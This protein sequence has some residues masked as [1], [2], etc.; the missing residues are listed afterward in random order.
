MPAGLF[1]EAFQAASKAVAKHQVQQ[2]GPDGASKDA[3]RREPEAKGSS[4]AGPSQTASAVASANWPLPAL[5]REGG[6]R[7]PS[8]GVKRSSTLAGTEAA[9]GIPGRSELRALS[10]GGRAAEGTGQVAGD[11]KEVPAKTERA[12][13]G[14]LAAGHGGSRLTGTGAQDARRSAPEPSKQ[15][16]DKTALGPNGANAAKE[17]V[18]PSPTGGEEASSDGLLAP[19]P[20]DVALMVAQAR[21]SQPGEHEPA[22]RSSGAYMAAQGRTTRTAQPAGREALRGGTSETGQGARQGG[23]SATGRG[24]SSESNAWYRHVD[25]APG[26]GQVGR[27]HPTEAAAG[28]EAELGRQKTTAPLTQMGAAQVPVGGYGRAAGRAALGLPARDASAVAPRATSGVQAKGGAKVA[29]V[30]AAVAQPGGYGGSGLTLS[31]VPRQLGQQLGEAVLQHL[32]HLAP[33]ERGQDG[34]W[35]LSVQLDPPALGKV[36]ALLSLGSSGLS[37]VLVPSTPAAWQALQQASHQI[38]AN[39]GGH[40]TVSLHAGS[41]GPE[42]RGGQHPAASVPGQ[43]Q[44]SHEGTGADFAQPR[45]RPFRGRDGYYILA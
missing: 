40:V 9:S 39:I 20:R 5:L 42:E 14:G 1:A 43:R 4:H 29:A 37:V 34:T 2:D 10:L 8:E 26:D 19:A 31:S 22:P 3:R 24:A 27:T 23:A 6:Q 33:P 13:P 28:R 25:I 35:A 30:V 16:V 7:P 17:H 12:E 45:R 21:S 44:A 38:A 36:D 41:A 11:E 18:T 32:E 15:A